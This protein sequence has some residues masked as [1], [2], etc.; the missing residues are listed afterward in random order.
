MTTRIALTE[1]SI[2][3]LEPPTSGR[4]MIH[5]KRLPGFAIRITARGVKTLCL[6]RRIRGRPTIVTL[7]RWPG[8]NVKAAREMAI[9][10]GAQISKG[11]NPAAVRKAQ[12]EEITLGEF[13][14]EH[15]LDRHL[16]AHCKSW[17]ESEGV[18][19]RYLMP[20]RNRQLSS[21][22][23]GTIQALHS[24]IGASRTKYG[25][26]RMASLL[27]HVFRMAGQ[28]GFFEGENPAKGV[29]HF[30]ETKRDRFLQPE[31]ASALF[32]AIDAEPDEMFRDFF[33]LL[34]FTGARRNNVQGMAWEDI[35]FERQ[36]WVIPGVQ[37]KNK[38]PMTIPLHSQALA[39]LHNRR[40]KVEGEYVFPSKTPGKHLK[41]P[42]IRWWRIRKAA[43]LD[44]LRLHDLRRS[45]GSWMA[46]TGASLTVI[47]KTLGHESLEATA[48]Y[49]RLNIDPVRA[50]M[51]TGLDAMLKAGGR[52]QTAEVVKGPWLEKGGHNASQ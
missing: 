45:L 50:A 48:I 7:G 31:E 30:H 24:R 19:R 47:G 35:S 38:Q 2:E 11:E 49:A 18:Y 41:N 39:I 36:V 5:D 34:I 29:Q 27:S 6:Y 52:Q 33:W 44:D 13:F 23:N 37:S 40:A 15:Y 43:G 14:E 32:Q 20:W 26:N 10:M 22:S 17:A 51:E 25:A 42:N 16:K 46:G 8:L 3:K 1:A 12:R 21:I 9:E 4:A 28:W